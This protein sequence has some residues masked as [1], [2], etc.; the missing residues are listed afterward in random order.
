M[1]LGFRVAPAA[2][3]PAPA[4][5]DR[6]RWAWSLSVV[7][8]LVPFVGLWAHHASGWPI[9]LALRHWSVRRLAVVAVAGFALWHGAFTLAGWSSLSAAAPGGRLPFASVMEMAA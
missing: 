3:L 9:A 1:W 8:P 5:R 7:W 4:Y 2:A 6:K